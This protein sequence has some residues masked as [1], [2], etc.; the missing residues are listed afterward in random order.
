MS[1]RCQVDIDA[2]VFGIWEV[3][4]R[5]Y[6]H[7][8]QNEWTGEWVILPDYCA[9]RN[10]TWYPRNWNGELKTSWP[11]WS[12]VCWMVVNTL[13]PRQNGC[14]LP[15]DNFKCIFLNEDIQ[16]SIKTPLKFVPKGTI[17]NIP[18][19][20][21]I[22]AWHRPSSKPLSE[23]IMVSL[24]MHICTTRPQWVM[25]NLTVSDVECWCYTIVVVKSAWWLAMACC[26]FGTRASAIILA[27]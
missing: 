19:L 5:V 13:R 18:A 23:P 21:Q 22:M 9:D 7:R 16:I 12:T 17:N 27:M 1:D 25:T 2:R 6:G 24:L 11:L 8:S 10:K 26:L 15:D 20:V 14:Q 4:G 3:C